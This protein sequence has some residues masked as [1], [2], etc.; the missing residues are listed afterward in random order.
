MQEIIIVIALAVLAAGS[1]TDIKKREVPD[2]LNYG[3]MVFGLGTNLLLSI[4]FW[5]W[6]YIA[7]S[8]TGMLAFFAIAYVMFY[9]GQWGGGDSKMLI[10][11]GAVFG[12]PLSLTSPYLNSNS[13]L[14]SFWFNLLLAGV[15]YAFLW[16]IIIAVRNRK[17]FVKEAKIRLNKN[18]KTRRTLLLIATMIFLASLVVDDYLTKLLL[19]T[20]AS[21]SILMIYMSV[22]SKSVE[23]V[24]M[25]KLVKPEV[26]TEGDWIAK[27]ISSG[28]KIIAGPKDLGI[29][30]KQIKQL[31]KL[32]SQK[33]IKKVL[34]KVGIPFVPSFLVAFIVTI[35]Y[36]N[37]LLKWVNI[38]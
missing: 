17:K 16:S 34:I 37:I 7:Y 19:A 11:L 36:G 29:S 13:F 28:K 4:V 33:K 24:G 21:L 26:L 2:W 8:I 25:L 18:V 38:F 5:T 31:N 14:I 20:F 30:K 3:L 23:K 9:T 32:Y 15:I 6:T 1:Y 35:F 12:L 10:G 27:N 22:F